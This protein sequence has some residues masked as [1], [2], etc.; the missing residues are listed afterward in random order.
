MLGDGRDGR[1]GVVWGWGYG[2]TKGGGRMVF[3]YMRRG[4]GRW[5]CGRWECRMGWRGWMGWM[6]GDQLHWTYSGVLEIFR[7]F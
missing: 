3:V 1:D 2:N 5:E 7:G 6:D 4:A